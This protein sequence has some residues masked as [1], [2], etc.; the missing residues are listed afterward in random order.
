VMH[1]IN[2]LLHF[3]ISLSKFSLATLQ[4]CEPDDFV[5]RLL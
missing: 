2:A 3:Q 5:K 1:S 4:S